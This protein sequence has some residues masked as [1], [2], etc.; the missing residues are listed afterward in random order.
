MPL[1]QSLLDTV[2]HWIWGGQDRRKD[3]TL[4]TKVIQSQGRTQ[5]RW[6][7]PFGAYSR[8]SQEAAQVSNSSHSTMLHVPVHAYWLYQPH[9]SCSADPKKGWSSRGWQWSTVRDKGVLPTSKGRKRSSLGIARFPMTAQNE[10][11]FL[12]C[13]VHATVHAKCYWV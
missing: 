3:S 11:I 6:Q 10:S 12:P 5:V 8:D 7:H 13:T 4:E 2:Q 9:T 1:S